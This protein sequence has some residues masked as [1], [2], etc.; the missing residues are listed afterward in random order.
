MENRKAG[1]EGGKLHK[2]LKRDDRGS[3]IVVVIIAMALIGILVS[4]ILWSS[5]M[6]YMIKLADIRNKNSFYS[7]ETVMEQ[8][9]AG[10][11]HEASAAVTLSYQD[12]MKNWGNNHNPDDLYGS[13]EYRYHQFVTTYLDTLVKNLSDP[14]AGTGIYSLKV[15]QDFVDDDL[16]AGV[17]L[18]EWESGS[19]RMEIVNNASLVLYDV[20]VSY[21]DAN[22]YVSIIHTDITID[23]PKLVFYQNGSIDSLYE[24]A[25]IGNSGIQTE[26]GS[27]AALVDGSIYAGA[28][29]VLGSGGIMVNK[30]SSMTVK[31]GKLVIS[32]GDITVKGPGAGFIVRDVP[33]YGARVYAAGLNL[34]NGTLSLDSKTYVAN[35]LILSGNGSRATL[36]KEYYGYGSSMATGMTESEAVDTALSSAIIINGRNAMVDMSGVTRLLLAGRAYIGQSLTSGP[37]WSGTPEGPAGSS[38]AV[39]MGESIAV[40][41]NQIAYLVPAECVGTLSSKAAGSGTESGNAADDGS[42]AGSGGAAGGTTTADKS[43][44]GKTAIGQNPLN[45]KMAAEMEDYK[46]KYGNQFAEVDFYKPV[47]KLGNKTLSDFGVTD[48]NH[49]RKVYTQYNSADSENKTLVYYYLVMDKDQA[50]EYFEQYYNFNT[51][52][53]VID[54]YFKKYAT[55]GIM[56][57]DY[58]S[59]NTQ[60]TILGNSLVSSALSDSGVTLLKGMQQPVPDEGGDEGGSGDLDEGDSEE[61]QPPAEG[62]QEVSDNASEMT[63][64]QT[65]E[66]VLE[67]SESCAKT[68]KA[69]TTNLTEDA[70]S[71]SPTQT[72]FNSII[73]EELLRDYLADNGGT[74]EF[75]T[76]DGL[77]AVLTND[78]NYTVSDSKVRLVVA[79]D[80]DDNEEDGIAGGNI[81]VN[82]NFTGLIIAQGKITVSGTTIA[83]SRDKMGTYKVLNQ[84]RSN[85]DPQTPMDF[86]VNGSGVL[87]E[88]VTDASKVD[89]TGILNIDL[90]EIVR[91]TNWIK[92]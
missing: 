60:Y 65:E 51:N 67:F 92:K 82:A 66:E 26:N 68:F 14:L 85:T 78:D 44:F 69:L 71:V 29:E 3:A 16:F 23:V 38:K 33:E 40:K 35:D 39:L 55:G 70:S 36:T 63:N 79:I 86:F 47:Y 54:G 62:Y 7:A 81:T 77:K 50:A 45:G 9:M 48:M 74:V 10:M 58:T 8:I 27:G 11:Q 22:D 75:V 25:L 57:G 56:L 30:A 13:E 52:K 91:Y 37:A 24:Y 34:E 72:V 73:R 17:D 64:V 80:K 53:E 4:A 19:R 49:I 1:R 32:K 41:G 43:V 31:E 61:E 42:T 87:A 59:E 20:R 12:V 46:T 90:S 15:L 88:E 84:E 6:N 76:D 5:Y 83:V 28:D 21:A 2:G 18:T 89:E